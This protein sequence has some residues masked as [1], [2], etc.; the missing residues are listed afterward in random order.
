[1][2]S[3]F[4]PDS[5]KIVIFFQY[6]KK[7]KFQYCLQFL[8]SA[9][10]LASCLPH[11]TTP[12]R[13]R[14]AEEAIESRPSLAPTKETI[15]NLLL[16]IYRSA[17]TPTKKYESLRLIASFLHGCTVDVLLVR[18]LIRDILQNLRR[19]ISKEESNG[20]ALVL[21]ASATRDPT[22]VVDDTLT[23]LISTPKALNASPDLFVT[24]L[25]SLGKQLVILNFL[26][27]K[28]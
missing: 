9:H 22:F 1:M 2:S 27:K 21:R 14:T 16:T 28:I 8:V 19:N 18:S 3:L 11:P 23:P 10:S 5:L 17:E 7:S 13:F 26:K 4:P 24:V 20:L 12:I 15:A 6:A 25:R